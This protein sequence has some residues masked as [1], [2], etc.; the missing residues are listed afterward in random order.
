MNSWLWL[1]FLN[2]RFVYCLLLF[3]FVGW[4]LSIKNLVHLLLLYLLN[5]R[6]EDLDIFLKHYVSFV[7]LVMRV[8]RI[9]VIL[10]INYVTLQLNHLSEFLKVSWVLV[11]M[12]R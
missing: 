7:L 8:N 4:V 11:V 2:D 12:R 5:H 10:L 6:L 3:R 1:C 9:I